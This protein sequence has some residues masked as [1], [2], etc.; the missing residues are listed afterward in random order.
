MRPQ[1]SPQQLEQRRLQAIAWLR[2]GKTYRFVAGA[3]KASLS[4][5]VRWYQAYRRGK[6]QALRP[7]RSP[8]RPPG[9]SSAQKEQLKQVLLQG[10][11]QAGYSTDVWTLQRI[12]RLIQRHFGVSYTAVGVWKLM[13]QGLRWSWQKPQRRAQERDEPAIARWK[14]S[15]WPGIKKS[16]KTWRPSGVSGRK[17]LSAHS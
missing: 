1:G 12:A 8:G 16:P 7:R 2:A 6:R 5:V 15:T 10:A 9:L 14:R 17:R 3:L 4:S 11:L 13:H